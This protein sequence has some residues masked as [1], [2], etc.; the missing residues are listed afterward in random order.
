MSKKNSDDAKRGP[1][2]EATR[3]RRMSLAMDLGLLTGLDH[4]DRIRVTCMKDGEKRTQ[5]QLGELYAIL[6]RVSFFDQFPTAAV[7]DLTRVVQC[8]TTK[9]WM[10]V[11]KQGQQG[12]AIFFIVAGACHVHK[13]DENKPPMSQTVAPARSTGKSKWSVLRNMVNTTS[14]TRKF[15]PTQI[16]EDFLKPDKQI[17]GEYG[18][19]LVSG[20]PAPTPGLC[21]CASSFPRAP[22]R[23]RPLTFPRSRR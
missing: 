11:F 1:T 10:E 12:E 23:A 20:R 18:K 17:E 13:L 19:F 8:Y 2:P 5:K 6:Q 22:P 3:E 15:K 7:W 14:K 16:S 4:L 21:G 9:A